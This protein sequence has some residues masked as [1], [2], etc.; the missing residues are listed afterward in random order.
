MRLST[1]DYIVTL[2]NYSSSEV[3]SSTQKIDTTDL[4]LPYYVFEW[5]SSERKRG[6]RGRRLQVGRVQVPQSKWRPLW[7]SEIGNLNVSPRKRNTAAKLLSKQGACIKE[8][9]EVKRKSLAQSRGRQVMLWYNCVGF[10]RGSYKNMNNHRE[11]SISHCTRNCTK[12]HWVWVEERD[13]LT[14]AWD[15]LCRTSQTSKKTKWTC[16][17]VMDRKAAAPHL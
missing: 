7:I 10:K 4:P 16:L 15:W 9:T 17:S 8:Q 11:T 5:I 13:K 12:C 2:S 14:Q 6:E 3:V 1:V